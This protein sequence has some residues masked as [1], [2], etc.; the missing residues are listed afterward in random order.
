M[1]WRHVTLLHPVRRLIQRGRTFSSA[2]A[3][4]APAP[5]S[6]SRAA[7]IDSSNTA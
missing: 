7:A 1:R 4:E 5:E 6:R 3:A 2:S